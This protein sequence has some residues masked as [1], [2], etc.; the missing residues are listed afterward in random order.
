M[1]TTN[2]IE[3]LNRQLR[4]A[5][6][7]KGHSPNEDAARKPAPRHHQRRATW[8]KTRN[9]TARITSKSDLLESKSTS[10]TDCRRP[11]PAAVVGRDEGG[12]E[13]RRTPR[14][15]LFGFGDRDVYV[16]ADFPDNES[17]VG[18]GSS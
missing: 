17:A 18:M 9:W 3:A 10:E 4:K 14:Q 13:R 2:P 5:I 15:F 16:I 6:K 11:G 1:Y 7:T 12:G 8:T